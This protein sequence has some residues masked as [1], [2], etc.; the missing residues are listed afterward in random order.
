MRVYLGTNVSF[1]AKFRM[2]PSSTALGAAPTYEL[3]LKSFAPKV[4]FMFGPQVLPTQSPSSF[5]AFLGAGPLVGPRTSTSSPGASA[6]RWSY[7]KLVKAAVACWRSVRGT[8]PVFQENW[9]T[10]MGAFQAG[11]RKAR[12]HASREKAGY[13]ARS[14]GWAGSPS[15]IGSGELDDDKNGPGRF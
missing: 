13:R 8:S 1:A 12:S 14:D 2:W 6:I 9:N 5:Y 15:A 10:Q 7:V 3:A 4:S 11:L